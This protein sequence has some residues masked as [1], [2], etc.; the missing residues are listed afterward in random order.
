MKHINKTADSFQWLD[1][2][3]DITEFK[4]FIATGY[5]LKLL[6]FMETIK[7]SKQAV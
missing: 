1:L 2:F 4:I 3:Y 6:C 5:F 7:A